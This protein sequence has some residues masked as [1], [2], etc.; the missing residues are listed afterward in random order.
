M[1]HCRAT[2]LQ[3]V[4]SR[5]SDSLGLLLAT[6]LMAAKASEAG[7]SRPKNLEGTSTGCQVVQNSRT[8]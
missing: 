8:L 3:A 1:S 4:C 5:S 2:G 7:P 6:E